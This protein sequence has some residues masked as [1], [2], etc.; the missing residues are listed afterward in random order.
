MSVLLIW[1][2]VPED[3]KFYRLDGE[4]AEAAI[5]AHGCYVNMFNGDPNGAADKLSEMLG[6]MEPMDK[7]AGPISGEGI[8]KIVMSGFLL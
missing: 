2:E 1:E 5:A 6:S 3:T 7:E 8:D 4:L